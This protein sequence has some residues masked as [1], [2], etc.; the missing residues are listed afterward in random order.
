MNKR[1]LEVYALSVCFVSIGC[2][3][4]FSGIFLY[5]LV[6]I[7][8]P[9]AMKPIYLPPPPIFTQ[10]GAGT[11]PSLPMQ[12][13]KSNAERN[14]NLIEEQKR[15]E[16]KQDERMEAESIKSIVRSIIIVFIASLV[17][18]FHRRI[19]KDARSNET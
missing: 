10:S 2:L 3:S 18:I 19:A 17:F 9:S 1:L 14:E 11:A 8:F 13:I 6:E 16:K 7:S 15:F 12:E 4:I 5:G